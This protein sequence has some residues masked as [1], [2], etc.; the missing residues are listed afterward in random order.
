MAEKR[1]KVSAQEL[2]AQLAADPAHQARFRQQEEERLR[3]E[4]ELTVAEAPLVAELAA[5]GLTVNSVWDLVNSAK[6][7]P[8]AIPIL[9]RHLS[10]SYPDRIREGIARALAVPDARQAWPALI[11]AF[12]AEPQSGTKQGLAAALAAITGDDVLDELVA[13]LRDPKHGESRVLLVN[14]LGRSRDPRARRALMELGADPVLAKQVQHVLKS[15][16]KQ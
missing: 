7:Y 3:W 16:R 8:G 15:K 10:R 9:L 5:Q 1:K 12:R 13:L 6:P 14:P 4:A 11:A 2:A